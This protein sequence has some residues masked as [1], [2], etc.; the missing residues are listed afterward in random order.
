MLVSNSST[1]I[2]ISKITL[3]QKFLD[4]VK[5]VSI[6]NVIYEEV[7]KKDS[8]ENLI[9][10]KEVEKGRIKIVRIE[11]KRYSH[12][13]KQ[14]KLD[15]GEAS[16]FALY[17]NGKYKAV[18]TDDKE[19]IKI[20][21]INNVPFISA[22]AIIAALFRKKIISKNEALEKMENLQGYGRYSNEI[23]SYFRDMVR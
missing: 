5:S 23:Y 15:E 11:E 6:T 9:I 8:F 20:C 19:L 3:L 18:L 4:E 14:F 7:L 10:K 22:M 12:I 13:I 2:L 16:A 17:N 1:I 21:K